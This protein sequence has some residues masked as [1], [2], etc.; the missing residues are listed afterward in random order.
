MA[1]EITI[2]DAQI[3]F[4]NFRGEGSAY[5][6]VGRRTFSVVLRDEELVN[7]LISDG[8]N[9][10]MLKKREEDDEQAWHLPVRCKFDVRSPKIYICTYPNG[11]LK[12]TLLDEDSVG[13]L[14]W[15]E[16][17]KVD[18]IV[19]PYQWQM[20]GREGITA[21]LKVMYVTVVEDSLADD[22]QEDEEAP[23]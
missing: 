12:K 20:N 23:F 3:I 7:D 6:P 22:Y 17:A 11:K 9:I 8:W 13:M 5:N 14:D 4:R 15:A 19:S 2:K 18:L 16:L 10:K 21:Y 1:N